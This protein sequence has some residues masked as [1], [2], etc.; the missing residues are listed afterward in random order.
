MHV[1]R[2]RL[3]RW[4]TPLA[5]R[6]PLSPNQITLLALLINLSAAALLYVRLFIPAVILLAVGGL[7]D[8]F[9]GVVARVQQKTS[10]YGD[11][12]DH[13]ADRMSDVMLI[14]GWMLGMGVRPIVTV[15]AIIAV[16]LNGYS[17][18]QIE[19]TFHERRY[20]S[21]GRGEFVLAM[22]VLPIGSHVLVRGGW[23]QIAPGGLLLA[24]WA[25]IV[26][27]LFAA[28]GIAQRVALAHRLER[29]A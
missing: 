1:W 12:L 29:S 25:T 15:L 14:S 18:T 7:A 3:G 21:V 6:C 28:I 9:D 16:T 4:F 13:L 24:E 27:M 19:A 10:R 17:G 2:E 20:D 23:E 26:L 5:L 22:V 8:A 11:F